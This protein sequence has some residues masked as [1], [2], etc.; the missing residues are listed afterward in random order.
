MGYGVRSEV[1]RPKGNRETPI[2]REER[3]KGERKESDA[4]VAEVEGNKRQKD[5][6]R[7]EVKFAKYPSHLISSRMTSGCLY[8]L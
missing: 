1:T 2:K 6:V 3:E 7:T 5:E 8:E 4:E